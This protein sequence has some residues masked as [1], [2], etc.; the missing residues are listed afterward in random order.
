M[1]HLLILF[2]T[3]FSLSAFAQ[4]DTVKQKL[5]P[6]TAPNIPLILMDS[7]CRLPDEL[8]ILAMFKHIE[9]YEI[10]KDSSIR[11]MLS[12][13]Y[14]NIQYPPICRN[15]CYPNRTAVIGFVIEKDGSMSNAIIVRK[16]GCN[17]G[18][19]AL[20]VVKLLPQF[21]PGIKNGK[22][23]RVQYYLPIRFRLE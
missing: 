7:I 10:R 22:P 19:E 13:I 23:V 9:D 20:R 2:F 4:I 11:E 14:E 21:S 5:Q 17:M 18:E 6:K 8:P 3:I 12:L 16:P 1:K 15:A